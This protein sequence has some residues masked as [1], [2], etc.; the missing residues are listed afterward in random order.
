MTATE[1][2]EMSGLGEL[3]KNPALFDV[4]G[5]LQTLVASLNGCGPLETELLRQ[6]AVGRLQELE[7]GE[8]RR[9]V[10]AAFA[11]REQSKGD[12]P[13]TQASA[14]TLADPELSPTAVDGESLFGELVEWLSDYISIPPHSAVAVALWIIAS[15]FVEEVDFAAILAA[16]S[17]TKR[18]GKSHLLDL[19]RCTARRGYLTSGSGVTT[20]VVFRLNNTHR[21]TLAIDEAERLAGRHADRELIA[22]LNAGYRRGARV[23]RCVERNGD[24]EVVDFDAFGFRAL[25]AIGRLWD[26]IL[27]RAI[28]VR[29]ERKARDMNLRRFSIRAVEREGLV[30]AGRLRRWATDNREAVG[31]AALET[32]RPAWLDDRACDNWSSLFAVAAVAG[33]EWPERALHAA[34]VLSR[35]PDAEDD[36]ERLVHDVQRLCQSERWEEA[37]KSGDLV[38]KLNELEGSP[39]G[40]Y[41]N[42]KGLST[43]R[44][45]AL[46]KPLGCGPQ[47]GRTAQGLVLRGYWLADLDPIFRRYPLPEP[48]SP[49]VLQVLRPLQESPHNDLPVTIAAVVTVEAKEGGPGLWANVPPPPKPEGEDDED[50]E[51]GAGAETN[52]RAALDALDPEGWE[53]ANA[54]GVALLSRLDE[55]MVEPLIDGSYRVIGGQRPH[56]VAADGSSC[57]CEDHRYRRRVCKHMR[58]VEG[59]A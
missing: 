33:G 49:E 54:E 57:D 51:G 3:R 38:A 10:A 46:F 5:C 50:P 4:A 43:H 21:P 1:L 17:A 20:A 56:H 52:L 26:T 47:L 2:L 7:V 53:P 44:L 58:A 12:A 30:F 23:Q 24:F 32:P 40:E 31:T 42:G 34:H 39:W 9:L 19:I 14:I 35:V 45:A 36:T 29:L 48:P 6:G 59:A 27:D 18:C 15:W 8:A 37:V 41:S 16:L 25:A 13:T 28:V 11:E 22:M 55:L